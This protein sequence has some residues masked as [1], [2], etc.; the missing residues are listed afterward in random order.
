MPNLSTVPAQQAIPG[1]ECLPRLSAVPLILP[2]SGHSTSSMKFL[3][4]SGKDQ[5]YF[6]GIFHMEYFS[7][8][9]CSHMVM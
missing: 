6:L 9:P 3:L 2:T 7:Y 4:N 5:I 8:M 1:L